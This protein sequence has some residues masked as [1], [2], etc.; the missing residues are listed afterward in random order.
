M[1]MIEKWRR[2]VQLEKEIDKVENHLNS[3]VNL[4]ER[5]LDEKERGCRKS[6]GVAFGEVRSSER[7]R[8]EMSASGLLYEDEGLFRLL[9]DTAINFLQGKLETMKSEF[10]E[11]YMDNKS[12]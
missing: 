10:D 3:L 11:L 5:L 7:M 2:S 4:K 1:R 6:Y 12:K 8:R 9:L